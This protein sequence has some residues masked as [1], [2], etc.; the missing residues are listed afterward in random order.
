MTAQIINGKLIAENLKRQIQSDVHDFCL[1]TSVVPTLATILVGHDPASHVYVKNKIASTE[2]CGMRSVH[3]E[4]PDTVTESELLEKIHSLNHDQSVHGILVQLPLPPSIRVETVIEAID[5]RKDVDGFHPANV[6]AL[7]LGQ[8]GFVPCTPYGVM[9]LLEAVGVSLVGLDVLVVGKSNIVGKPMANLLMNAQATVTVAH[10]KTKNLA[11][12]VS[13][14]D[15]V[16]VAVGRTHL[17]QGAWIKPGAVVI[18]VG[19]NRMTNG[20]LTGDVD[21]ELAKEKASHITPV[22]GGVGPMTIAV[23]LKNTL[24]ACQRQ[25]GKSL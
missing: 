9:L 3:I 20:K 5:P 15:V 17:I 10:S 25:Q 16:I 2:A 24:K 6:G 23:L 1:K 8:E 18:D 7:Q 13:Q 12:K 19:I 11:E 21:F 4:F 22:P 14:A